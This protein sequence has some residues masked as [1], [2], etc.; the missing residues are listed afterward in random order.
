M[1][2]GPESKVIYMGIPF[3]AILKDDEVTGVGPIAWIMDKL[4]QLGLPFDGW[5]HVYEG[6]YFVALYHWLFD[7]EEGG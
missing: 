3:R 1:H 2:H 7:E 6:N 4:F 5:V